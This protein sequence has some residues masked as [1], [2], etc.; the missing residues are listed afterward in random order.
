MVSLNITIKQKNNR[1]RKTVVE[2]D[3]DQFERMAA[4]F[5]LFN[6]DFL[7]SLEESEKDYRE[8]RVKRLRS[9]K[10]LRKSR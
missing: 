7:K 8:G 10:D 3:A 2:F 5:G 4:V 9:L 6:P 1:S